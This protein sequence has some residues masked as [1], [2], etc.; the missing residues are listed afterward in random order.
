[1]PYLCY[2]ITL[3]TERN[4]N[5][6]IKIEFPKPDVVIRQREQEVKPGDVPI[7]PYFG[8][9]DFHKIT[10]DKGGIFYSI[11]TRMSYYLSAKHVKFVNVLKSISRTMYLR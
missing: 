5:T 9:I 7:T 4:V 10:R 3:V 8:F 2:H 11:M 6:L 1:M